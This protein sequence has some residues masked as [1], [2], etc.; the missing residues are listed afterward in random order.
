MLNNLEWPHSHVWLS[1]EGMGPH[2]PSRLPE[3]SHILSILQ[4][5]M[6]PQVSHIQGV[7]ELCK[8]ANTREGTSQ[9]AGY[10]TTAHVK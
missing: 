10:H 3:L 8:G 5:P 9:K 1:A 4:C 6:V 7:R 2:V